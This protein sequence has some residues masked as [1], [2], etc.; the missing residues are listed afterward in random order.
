[1][2]ARCNVV[3]GATCVRVHPRPVIDS[4]GR[5]GGRDTRMS[6]MSHDESRMR[7]RMRESARTA[8]ETS[9]IL[10]FLFVPIP[11]SFQRV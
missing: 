7:I 2:R 8:T 4:R 1:M 10:P 9:W 3:G 11:S 6:T 5:E